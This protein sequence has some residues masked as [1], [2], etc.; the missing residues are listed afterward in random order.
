MHRPVCGMHRAVA[1][2]TPTRRHA[3]DVKFLLR[4]R[5]GRAA[6]RGEQRVNHRRDL[7]AFPRV[8]IAMKSTQAPVASR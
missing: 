5:D 4:V 2:L 6:R 1:R 8:V 3:R 7:R